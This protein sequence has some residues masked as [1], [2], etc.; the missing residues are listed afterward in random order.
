M[1]WNKS[2]SQNA[3]EITRWAHTAVDR[4]W[5]PLSKGFGHQENVAG[6]F[7]QGP[8]ETHVTIARRSERSLILQSRSRNNLRFA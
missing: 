7:S 6:V 2:F 3:E 5:N 4:S 1:Q 8:W